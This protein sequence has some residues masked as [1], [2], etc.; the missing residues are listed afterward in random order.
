MAL[1]LITLPTTTWGDSE[2]NVQIE[3]ATRGHLEQRLGAQAQREHWQGMRFTQKLLALPPDAPT[4][5]CTAP[6][7]VRATTESATLAERQR[8]DLLCTA[9]PGWRL[10]VTVQVSVFVQAVVAAKILERGGVITADMLERREVSVSKNSRGLF[11]QADEVIGLSAKRRIRSQQVLNQGMLVSPWLVR[12]GERVRMVAR[13]GEIQAVTQGEALKDGRSGQ[14]IQV[15]NLASGSIIDA[16][17]TEPG[18]V[19]STFIP[20][21]K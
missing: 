10:T 20:S 7:T 13:H 15:K 3:E 11:S 21:Q 8:L 4:A 14:V 9:Q 5:A 2:L 18:T 16:Q 12:R 6:L 1:L 19:T 17:V